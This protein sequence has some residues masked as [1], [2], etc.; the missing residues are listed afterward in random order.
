MFDRTYIED[1]KASVGQTITLAGWVSRT[2]DLKKIRFIVLRDKTGDIQ[3]VVKPDNEQLFNLDL[4]REDVITVTGRAV[5]SN[6]AKAGVEFQA[7]SIEV[8]NK[9]AQPL[10][11]DI[12]ENKKSDLDTRLNYRFLD[13]RAPTTNAIFRIQNALLT[14]FRNYLSGN[15]YMEFQPPC[16]IGSASEGGADLFSIPYFEKMAFLAQSP[17]LYKQM[18]AISF[19]KVF[20]ITPIWR[21]EK[22]NTPTHLNEVRQ[23]DIEQVF[24]D[25]ETVMGVLENTLVH[26]L[27]EAKEKT[28]EQLK[29]L[30]R[31]LDIPELPFRRIT[32]TESIQMLQDEGESILWG[33]DF[34]KTQEKLLTELVGKEAFFLKDWPGAQKAFYA[35]P[36]NKENEV[37]AK[38]LEETYGDVEMGDKVVRAFDCLYSGIEISSGTMRIHMPEL[39]RERIRYK[40]LNPDNFEYYT[41]AFAY[42]APPHAGWSI[43]L[44]R[45][46]MTV[47]GMSNIRE[48]CM[49]PRDRDRLVP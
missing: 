43:G 48:C 29:L 40:G 15:G 4:G 8:I 36:Y 1:A 35:M 16:I 24:S 42:G 37:D 38:Y 22:F 44:E 30:G 17:Q 6:V 23:M 39:L 31:E 21:A 14:A 41:G 27:K 26:M 33:D 19:E 49:F 32:Y 46:T 12:M 13:F 5:E 47:T 3:V 11:V 34:T 45:I 2:R 20:T 7:D 28:A 9:S 10:P 25:D 18:C